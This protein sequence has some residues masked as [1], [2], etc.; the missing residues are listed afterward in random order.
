VIGEARGRALVTGAGGFLGSHLVRALAAQGRQVV[1]LDRAPERLDELAG[2]GPIRVL[3]ADIGDAAAVA[4]ALDGVE[5]VFHLAAAHLGVLSAPGEFER[6]NVAAAEGL[7]R[8]AA[9]AGVRR[10]VHTSSVGVYGRIE[11]PPA[12]EDTPCRPRLVYERTKLAGEQAALAAARE[13]GLPLVVLRPVWVYGPGCPRTEKLFRAISRGRFVIGGRGDRLRHCVYVEDMVQAF[14]R[15]ECTDAALGHVLVVG[16]REPV[17]IRTLVD[18]IAGLVGARPPRALPLPLLA[19]AALAAEAVFRPLGK[20]PPISRRT[21][22][23]FTSNTA[24]RTERAVRLLG[25]VPRYDLAAGLA[26]TWRVL[27][28]GAGATPAPAPK[29]AGG[30]PGAGEPGP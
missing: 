12:D 28:Q 30:A 18:E 10:F 19:A 23:F 21:L 3:Q 1:A 6:V 24:F 26:E 8:A 11:R 14:L 7:V 2:A 25:F 29:P 16:D 15:A 13:V 20:E 22:E 9:R 17:A 5:T 27:R 4:A